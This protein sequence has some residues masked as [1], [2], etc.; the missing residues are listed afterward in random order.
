[1]HG[2]VQIYMNGLRDPD[3]MAVSA[4]ALFREDDGEYRH[5][6]LYDEV[7]YACD[8]DRKVAIEPWALATIMQH[9]DRIKA[10]LAAAIEKGQRT[11]IDEV[12]QVK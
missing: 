7:H 8:L 3:R 4:V 9:V 12:D 1:M 6:R 5:V 2:T 10:A 11:L